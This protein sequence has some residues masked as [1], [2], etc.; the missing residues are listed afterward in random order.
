MAAYERRDHR[1][2]RAAL[3]DLERLPGGEAVWLRELLDKAIEQHHAHR[4]HLHP[5]GEPDV[6]LYLPCPVPNQTFA[7][8]RIRV[9]PTPF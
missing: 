8:L 3:R 9:L 7:A 5:L 6:V 1:G 2:A 4:I